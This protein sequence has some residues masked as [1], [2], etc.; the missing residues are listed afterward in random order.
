MM[1]DNRLVNWFV[2]KNIRGRTNIEMA[3][4]FVF[5]HLFGPMIA[6][7]MAIYLYIV[8]PEVNYQLEVMVAGIYSFLLLTFVLKYTGS[9][10]ISSLL[11]FVGLAAVSLFGTYHYGGFSSPFL[12]WLIVSLLLGFFYLSKNTWL[13]I[14]LFTA[15]VGVFLTFLIRNGLPNTV[16]V[17]DLQ[18]LSWLSIVAATVYMSWMAL[19]YARIIA[20]RSE[21]QHEAERFRSTMEELEKARAVS[22][23]VS[24][25]RSLFFSK[26]SH[27]LRT[28]LNVIIGYSEILLDD[29]SDAKDGNDQAIKDLVRI[30]KAGKHLLSL[31]SEVLDSDKIVNDVNAVDV[32]EFTLGELIDEVVASAFP[33]VVKNGN[34]F[35]IDCPHREAR[36]RTDRTKLRQ[37]LINLLSNAGKFTKSGT[38]T[39]KLNIER[40]LADD[41][42]HAVVTDTGIGIAPDVLPKLFQS[43]IQADASISKRFGG[44]GIGLAITRKFAILLG[45]EITVASRPGEGTQFTIDIPA[46]IETMQQPQPVESGE[47]HETSKAA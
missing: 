23:E 5:T 4:I 8:S 16:P 3:R 32:S 47:S 41:R 19:Y 43:Y 45:G 20:L 7:P 33:L 13:V 25:H 37:M 30:N 17:E 6:Q 2:P 28:P 27:E 34:R 39:M 46:H 9:M 22:E 1:M 26:M 31:V 44:T 40:S 14:G 11:S 15:I 21:L 38:V 42:F 35:D 24:H 36:L 29:A 10:M 12:P 18:I